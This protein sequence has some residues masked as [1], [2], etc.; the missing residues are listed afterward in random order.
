MQT[1]KQAILTGSTQSDSVETSYGSYGPVADPAAA[2]LSCLIRGQ[3]S[4]GTSQAVAP[5]LAIRLIALLPNSRAGILG[6]RTGRMLN[7]PGKSGNQ[8]M[9][10]F[11]F[12]MSD[13]LTAVRQEFKRN[14]RTIHGHDS[15]D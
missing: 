15:T 4:S 3:P 9:K 13:Y 11:G 1:P 5:S 2:P 10:R 8:H 6:D 7:Q 14:D 12:A